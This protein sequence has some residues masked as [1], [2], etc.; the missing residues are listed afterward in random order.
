MI[1]SGY[2]RI[3]ERHCGQYTAFSP[4]NIIHFPV[5]TQFLCPFIPLLNNFS[6]SY[7]CELELKI[8]RIMLQGSKVNV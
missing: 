1:Y 2:F 3:L 8:M 6:V 7:S 5:P 4:L